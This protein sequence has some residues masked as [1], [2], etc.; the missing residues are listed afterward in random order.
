MPGITLKKAVEKLTSKVV[1]VVTTLNK[2]EQKIDAQKLNKT[3]HVEFV[4]G[5]TTEIKVG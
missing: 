3:I 1:E 4:D 2:Q 5:T